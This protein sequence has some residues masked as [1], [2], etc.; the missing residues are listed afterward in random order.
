VYI[1]ISIPQNDSASIVAKTDLSPSS[2]PTVHLVLWLA[3]ARVDVA[4]FC[5]GAYGIVFYLRKR[6]CEIGA[7]GQPKSRSAN[8]K[9][10]ALDRRLT[11]ADRAAIVSEYQA[12]ELQKTLAKKYGVSL[13]SV[14]RLI[15]EARS[16]NLLA[17]LAGL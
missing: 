2:S 14:K 7:Y 8:G 6:T 13:S 17:P 1:D 12:G 9:P 10:W 15:R 16:T 11:S 4:V 3:S 5:A